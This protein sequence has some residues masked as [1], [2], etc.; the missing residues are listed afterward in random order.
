MRKAAM[1]LGTIILGIS[2][3]LGVATIL[4]PT[5][6]AASSPVVISAS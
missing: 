5:A 6:Q 4:T 3:M 2:T 1:A